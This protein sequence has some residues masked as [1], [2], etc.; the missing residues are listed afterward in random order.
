MGLV[1]DT[2]RKENYFVNIYRRYRWRMDY[3]RWRLR[4]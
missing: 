2:N 1:T 4:W 3:L